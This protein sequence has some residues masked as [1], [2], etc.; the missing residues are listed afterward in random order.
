MLFYCCTVFDKILKHLSWQIVL[1]LKNYFI[2]KNSSV[3][4]AWLEHQRKWNIWV[5]IAA[6]IAPWDTLK[7]LVAFEAADKHAHFYFNLLRLGR[8]VP[9][10]VWQLVLENYTV[11]QTS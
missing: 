9:L 10:L 2:M 11:N 3:D 5:R 8:V 7:C 4:L 6:L 1:G